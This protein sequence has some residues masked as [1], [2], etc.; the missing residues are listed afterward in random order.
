MHHERDEY[1]FRVS[2]YL[3]VH[4]LCFC[5][6]QSIPNTGEI[7]VGSY[8]CKSVMLYIS[9]CLYFTKNSR[10]SMK[11]FVKFLLPFRFSDSS[12][13]RS[14]WKITNLVMFRKN[15]RLITDEIKDSKRHLNYR[16]AVSFKRTV[17]AIGSKETTRIAKP[18]THS[19]HSKLYIINMYFITYKLMNSSIYSTWSCR[20]HANKNKS[21]EQNCLFTKAMF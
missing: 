10:H 15:I 8:R 19:L 17:R 20:D 7:K 12:L 3:F 9:A 21:Y 5:C 13:T 14:P 4:V 1:R 18:D 11:S 6:L 2:V 16:H